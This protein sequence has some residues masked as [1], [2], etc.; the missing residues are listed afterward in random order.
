VD[1]VR[2]VG[3]NGTEIA[4]ISASPLKA[5]TEI[6]ASGLVVAPGFIDLHGRCDSGE[7]V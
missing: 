1:S 2:N 6:N 5:R 4:A 7:A 3:I